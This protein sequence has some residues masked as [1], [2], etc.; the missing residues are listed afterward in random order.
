MPAETIPDHE[1]RV[2]E[3]PVALLDEGE[4]LVAGE[5]G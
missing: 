1:K 2:L 3:V 5:V 4:D